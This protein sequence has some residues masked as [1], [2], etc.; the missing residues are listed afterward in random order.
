[1]D[2]FMKFQCWEQKNKTN[3]NTKLATKEDLSTDI[4]RKRKRN[5]NQKK[6][7]DPSK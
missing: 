2:N 4:A 3:E 6:K 7:N 1:M 5:R